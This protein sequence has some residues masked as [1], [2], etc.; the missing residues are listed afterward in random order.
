MRRRRPFAI[1]L[2]T[3][4]L[5]LALLVPTAAAGEPKV[6]VIAEGLDN[7]RGLT[8]GRNGAIYVTEAGTGGDLICMPGPEGDEVC[9]GKSG[10]VTKVTSH[11][12]KRVLRGLPSFAAPDGSGAIGPSDIAFDKHGKAF[13]TLGLGAD[14]AIRAGLP[15]GLKSAGWLIRA[16]VRNGHWAR[17]KDI[18]GFE[19]K[20]NPDGG[21]PDS[22]PN[23]VAIGRH[24]RIVVADAGGN[25]LLSVRRHHR[26]RVL[27]VFPAT[28]GVPGPFGPVDMQAVPTSVVR[29]PHGSWYVGQLTGF[30]FPVGGAKVFKVKP[31]HAPKVVAEGFTN[32]IDIAVAKDGSLLVLEIARNSILSGDFS[33]RLVKVKKD[34]SQKEI[35]IDGLFAPGGLAVGRNGAIYVSNNSILPGAGQVLKVSW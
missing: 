31:G 4:V 2:L 24:G 29:G 16:N 17:Y 13:V 10:A 33:G 35:V 30:P 1:S 27:A 21:V 6:R 19:A 34:G 12:Q 11:G 23:S 32:I 22:N 28:P 15:K 7:P 25:D 20:K 8:V 5:G 18:A 14:P 3:A 26:T 9:G